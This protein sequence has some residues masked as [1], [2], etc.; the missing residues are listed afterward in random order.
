MFLNSEELKS[1][2]SKAH[3]LSCFRKVG[4]VTYNKIGFHKRSFESVSAAF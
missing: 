2:A 3:A 4:A 1:I